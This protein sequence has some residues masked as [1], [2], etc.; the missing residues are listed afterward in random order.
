MGITSDFIVKMALLAFLVSSMLSTGMRL[1]LRALLASL[2]N[3]R[4]VVQVLILNF[5]VAPGFAWVLTKS[6]PLESGHAIGMLLLGGA[7]GAPFLPKLADAARGDTDLATAVMTLLTLGTI[8]FL[9]F[10]LPWLVA[11]FSASPWRIAQPLVLT[12]I[13]PL[14]LGMFINKAAGPFSLRV[15]PSLAI[16]GTV[17]LLVLF[18]LL[19]VLNVKQL[20]D[21][22]GS[23]AIAV[24]AIYV[25][26]LFAISWAA[27]FRF[28]SDQRGIVALATSA[29]NFG[30]ALVP[31]AGSFTD[32]A[33]T[34]MIIVSAIVGL[35]VCFLTTIWVRGRIHPGRIHP[36]RKG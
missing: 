23:G 34:I 31:A 6:I 13:L 20:L 16:I 29:R 4:L 36:G 7:A 18:V 33:V 19:I 35:A 24:S 28:Q 15:E 1:N 3:P 12:I 17:S 22:I 10:V 32:P 25:V 26:G 27:S 5:V 9:P 30:A 11:G 14:A 2:H 21:V 8:V